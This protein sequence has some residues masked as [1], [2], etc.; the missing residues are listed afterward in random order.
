MAGVDYWGIREAIAAV[1]RADANLYGVNVL[2]EEIFLLSPEQCPAVIVYLEDR[3]AV[4]SQQR[5]SAGMRTDFE[6]HFTLWCSCYSIESRPVAVRL[7]DE[8][9]AVVETALQHN[10]VL[11][12]TVGPLWLTGSPRYDIKSDAGFVAWGEVQLT[13]PAISSI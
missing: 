8:L 10:R 3:A 1:L 5:I 11:S 2:I 9:M 4:P 6:L 12:D 13:V 7:R